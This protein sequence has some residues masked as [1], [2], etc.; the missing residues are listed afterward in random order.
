MYESALQQKIL[1]LGYVLGFC[2]GMWLTVNIVILVQKIRS[3]MM[4]DKT[5]SVKMTCAD[6]KSKEQYYLSRTALFFTIGMTMLTISTLEGVNIGLALIAFLMGVV[7][8]VMFL[9]NGCRY[10]DYWMQRRKNE[11]KKIDFL[12]LLMDL[13]FAKE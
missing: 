5:K 9:F 11:G 7:L 3:E 8:L 12:S 6:A 1:D 10:A 13:M 4:K 2:I